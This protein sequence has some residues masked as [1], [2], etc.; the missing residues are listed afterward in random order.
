[1]QTPGMGPGNPGQPYNAPI[2]SP[3]GG[4]GGYGMSG[5]PKIRYD[6][7]GQAWNLVKPTLG[8]WVPAI[9][10]YMVVSYAVTMIM[11]SV[12][13]GGV[14]VPPGGQGVPAIDPMMFIIN[15]LVSIVVNAFFMGG[16]YRMAINQVR[17]RAISIGDLFSGADV[18]PALLIASLLMNIAIAIGF[19]LCIIPGLLLAGCLMFTIPL[20]VDKRQSAVDAMTLSFNTLKS[21]AFSA[22]GFAL[23][24][25]LVLIAGFLACGLGVLVTMPIALVAVT[26]LYR[27]FFP[28]NEAAQPGTFGYAAPPP[29][30]PPA[31]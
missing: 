15:Q 11:A 12:T 2:P 29:P 7:I 20:I 23:V 8:V 26:L 17:G 6:V 16:I 1:M 31:F 28:G 14:R 27:D 25:G 3:M 13:G 19:M 24:V 22:L 30:I 9:L 18:Y 10:I 4:S 21:Q 5:P